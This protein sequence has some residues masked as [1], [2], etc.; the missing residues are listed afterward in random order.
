MSTSSDALLLQLKIVNLTS[1]SSTGFKYNAAIFLPREK[2]D[3]EGKS[4]LFVF[5]SARVGPICLKNIK[6]LA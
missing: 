6:L 5:F 4:G 1:Y 3:N 2:E